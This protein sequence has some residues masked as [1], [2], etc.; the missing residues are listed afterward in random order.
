MRNVSGTLLVR[1]SVVAA[2]A[3]TGVYLGCARDEGEDVGQG[4][5]AIIGDVGFDPS[6]M[7][8][9]TVDAGLAVPNG[10]APANVQR[11]AR[12]AAAYMRT[13]IASPAFRECL[14]TSMARRTV[15]GAS[16][17]T[18][19]QGPYLPCSGDPAP[20]TVDVVMS[21]VTSTL[22]SNL[23][24]DYAT[25]G[26]STGGYSGVPAI[27]DA[28]EH[29]TYGN[30]LGELSRPQRCAF[31][32]DG[33]GNCIADTTFAVSAGTFLHE[34]M[35]AHHYNH[36]SDSVNNDETLMVGS[37]VTWT[38]PDGGTGSHTFTVDD[39]CG[40][41]PTA[42]VHPVYGTGMPYMVGGCI[43][44]VLAQSA[45][46]GH[47]HD[48]CGA[49]FAG[50]NLVHSVFAPEGGTRAMECVADPYT[51]SYDYS[52][53]D[54]GR[55][56]IPPHA[57][58]NCTIHP[59][60]PGSSK[61]TF[62]CDSNPNTLSMEERPRG[63]L[64]GWRTARTYSASYD[65]RVCAES[66]FGKACSTPRLGTKL[67][68]PQPAR[69]KPIPWWKQTPYARSPRARSR[70]FAKASGATI[71]A[72]AVDAATAS[73]F[74]ELGKSSGDL[75][76]EF[77]ALGIGFLNP[78]VGVIWARGGSTGTLPPGRGTAFAAGVSQDGT[79]HVIGF[80]GETSKGIPYAKVYDGKLAFSGDDVSASWS[81]SATTARTH[82][83]A[84]GSIGGETVY[85]FG[86]RGAQGHLGDLQAYSVDG[87]T[88]TTVLAA[89]ATPRADAAIDVDEASLYLFGGID[90]NGGVK[91]DLT[92]VDLAKKTTRVL[93]LAVTPRAGAAITVEKGMLYLYGGASSG[94][95]SD[96]F[97]VIDL[98]TGKVVSS[99]KLG[100][101]AASGSSIV[102]DDDGIVSIVPGAV[103]GAS[104]P[105]GAFVGLPG[106]MT[107]VVEPAEP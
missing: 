62:G 56:P 66:I 101:A 52:P 60:C 34:G 37:I 61:V 51:G 17:F 63:G 16:F 73:A 84:V 8:T 38:L 68:L 95:P 50:L 33:V 107:F 82:A 7:A 97:D 10:Q 96:A 4:S 88:M 41:T 98:A 26:T 67:C 83:S 58:T 54:P 100:V 15:I 6:C 23:G 77:A 105:G 1:G 14:S 45:E 42:T 92:I 22:K 20:P 9:P 18:N 28:G 71:M 48:E 104:V 2:M 53:N 81:A 78:N 89:A 29:F 91:S 44:T 70:A 43:T 75:A 31:N 32:P 25:L 90:A 12:V 86:G 55:A 76:P 69:F 65:Y 21:H 106:N 59:A 35:H 11:N 57:P 24:C 79:V 80:G 49:T 30:V 40:I 46:T 99:T 3:V 64:T 85:L 94:G 19:T 47:M 72:L 93:Q 103:Q 87:G 36:V 74:P 5:A 27:D 39:F 13:A 102:V